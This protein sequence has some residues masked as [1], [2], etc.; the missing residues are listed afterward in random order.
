MR[1]GQ[2]PRA[3]ARQL[4]GWLSTECP[5]DPAIRLLGVYPTEIS[6][7]VHRDT[8]V[9]SHGTTIRDGQNVQTTQTSIG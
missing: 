4:L 7:C 5:R 9:K 1:T 3:T 6:V 8:S 2:T